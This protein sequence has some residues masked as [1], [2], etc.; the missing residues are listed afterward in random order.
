MSKYPPMPSL[1][2]HNPIRH[3]PNRRV[4]SAPQDAP[5]LDNFNNPCSVPLHVGNAHA[6]STKE[7][8]LSFRCGHVPGGK[9]DRRVVLV[10][11]PPSIQ[12]EELGRK[13]VP[14]K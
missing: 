3:L 5:A 13:M 6:G 1:Q 10:L 9:G 4:T 2:R 12:A 8:V 7:L 11:P 14:A